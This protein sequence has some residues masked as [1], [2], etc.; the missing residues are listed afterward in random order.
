MTDVRQYTKVVL[1]LAETRI[2]SIYN[3]E[4]RIHII[5]EK[6]QYSS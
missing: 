1:P 6:R 3:R 4:D 5:L 2:G